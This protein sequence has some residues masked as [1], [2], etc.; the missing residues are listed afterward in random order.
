MLYLLNNVIESMARSL[1]C[2]FISHIDIFIDSRPTHLQKIS[3]KK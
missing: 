3:E 2:G 1:C